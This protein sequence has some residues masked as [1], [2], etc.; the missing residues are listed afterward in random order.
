MVRLLLDSGADVDARDA[1]FD[2]TPLA[3]ATVGS[4][5]QLGKPGNWIETVRLLLDADASRHDVWISGKPPSE[6]VIDLLQRYGITP[7]EST[8]QQPDDQTEVPGSI[9]TGVT[10]DIARHLE[11]AY[12]D[13]DA[14]AR[15]RT[16]LPRHSGKRQREGRRLP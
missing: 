16:A 12:R 10:A 15:H 8:G 9:G 1:R 5:E 4:G 2:S 13:H 11:T 6:E 14:S 3:F 7:D